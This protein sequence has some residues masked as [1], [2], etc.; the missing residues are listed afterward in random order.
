[1]TSLLILSIAIL[2][3][4]QTY[5]S[6]ISA[7]TPLLGAGLVPLHVVACIWVLLRLIPLHS[8]GPLSHLAHAGCRV[9]LCFW[10]L[11]F[12]PCT[13]S[14]KPVILLL[15]RH[16]MPPRSAIDFLSTTHAPLFFCVLRHVPE[17]H[18]QSPSE[19]SCSGHTSFIGE[20]FPT[21]SFF[22]HFT[23]LS[24]IALSAIESY[25]F[26]IT[27]ARYYIIP[28]Q[29]FSIQSFGQLLPL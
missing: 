10:L 25:F 22:P 7:A 9:S 8:H 27:L 6:V 28:F 21:K 3:P 11:L 1:M 29:V 13:T 26:S 14:I 4:M 12:L 24:T 15:P 2:S 19:L 23:P 18:Q 20:R 5:S 16:C 17:K